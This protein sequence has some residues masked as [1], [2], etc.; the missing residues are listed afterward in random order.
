ML[1]G[2]DPFE[3]FRQKRE[4]DMLER[5]FRDTALAKRK[6]LKELLEG[7]E[8]EPGEVER[9]VQEEMEAFF[10]ESAEAAES[11]FTEVGGGGEAA[12]EEIQ[13]RIDEVLRPV[14]SV[15]GAL[16]EEPATVPAS[17]EEGDVQS[18]LD[19]IRRHATGEPG[20]PKPSRSSLAPDWLDLTEETVDEA[21]A[22][23]TTG[24]EQD[25]H[26]R[27]LGAFDESLDRFRE[28]IRDGL[29]ESDLR[30]A[31]AAKDAE[32]GAE[33]PLA[34]RAEVGGFESELPPGPD[35]LDAAGVVRE[36][37]LEARVDVLEKEV[38]RLR[39]ILVRNGLAEDESA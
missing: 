12:R 1:Q 24:V 11:V 18:A 20:R 37:S 13:Q 28:M 17:S 25:R 21:E 10:R 14:E 32:T 15:P 2:S 6:R 19:R 16:T 22:E 3:D 31:I 23:E 34:R 9:Q 35:A 39:R 26:T 38:A 7:D 27:I 5:N 29:G 4:I 30:E 33:P 36:A 8:G